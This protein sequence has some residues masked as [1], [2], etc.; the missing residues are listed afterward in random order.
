MLLSLKIINYNN[1]NKLHTIWD[2]LGVN[3]F[4]PRVEY[5]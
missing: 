3:I 1:E 2:K 5:F 4:N